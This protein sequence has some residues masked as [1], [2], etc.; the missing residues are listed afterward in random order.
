MDANVRGPWLMAK[1]FG[2]PPDRAAGRPGQ[3]AARLLGPRP[4]R[5]RRRLQLLLD[6]Q[7]RHR[8]ADQGAG[9]RVGPARDQRQRGRARGVPLGADRVDLRGHRGRRRLAGA[10]HARIPLGRMGEPEDFI[11]I[12]AVPAVRGVR[13]RHRS[14][15]LR[16]RRLHRRHE[17]PIPGR[18]RRQ[19]RD[20]RG[21]R[22]A[23]WPPAVPVTLYDPDPGAL[24]AVAGADPGRRGAARRR[25]GAA[26]ARLPRPAA[27]ASAV[28]D[29]DLV[30]E[31]G[32]EVRA[33]KQEHVRRLAGSRRRGGAGLQHVGDPDPRD[34]RAGR[35]TGA[36]ARHALLEPAAAGAAGGGGPVGRDL[37]GA[38]R[39]PWRCCAVRHG[40]C[41]CSAD[42][43]GFVGNRLQHALKREAIALVAEGVCDAETLDTVVKEGFGAR[44]GVIG[45]LEQADLGGL[46]LTLQI[47]ES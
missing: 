33:V 16:G 5:Q 18:G 36:G 45:P 19:R 22:P 46:E 34:R 26:L 24:D 3:G 14:G 25:H 10:Q 32:P 43:P 21:H 7:G 28:A 9:H 17:T 20:G 12:V 38:S 2:R 6:L 30:I 13:L 4:P 42:V 39:G 23:S 8:R 29:A 11:G 1:A 40:R 35:A 47:H 41:T 27:S 31:A 15:D 37:P 44:L